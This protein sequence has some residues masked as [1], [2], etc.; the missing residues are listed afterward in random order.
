MLKENKIY[1]G[2]CLELMKQLDDHSIDM[3]LCD[4]PY[5]TTRAKWDSI[6][7]FDKLWEQYTRIIKGNGAIVLSGTE[8]FSSLLRCSNLSMY[9][10]DWVWDKIAPTG[11]FN[12]KKQPLRVTENISVFYKKQPTYN[13]QI[14]HNHERKTAKRRKAFHCELYNPSTEVIGYDSTDR[15]PIN[16]QSISSDKQKSHLHPTQ[17]PVELFKYLIRTYTNEGDLVLDNCIGSGTTAIACLEENRNYIG[18]E[19]EKKYYDIALARIEEWKNN[20][21]EIILFGR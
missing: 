12:A 21:K 17:K 14:T 5:G 11:F 8:P 3:I 1:N 18:M 2:D 13:P 16:L 7:P 4:L 20:S 19:K 6:I 10:Y 15:Y 9:K